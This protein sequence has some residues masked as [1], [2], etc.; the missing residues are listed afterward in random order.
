MDRL[1]EAEKKLQKHFHFDSFRLEQANVI[2][3]LLDEDKQNRNTL[4]IMP[5]GGGK[6]VCFQIPAVMSNGLTIV[7]SPLI[8]L[9]AD[10]VENL[11]DVNIKG[12][13]LNSTQTKEEA[14]AVYRDIFNGSL[15][16][17]YVSPEKVIA[18]DLVA[19]FL[20]K[21]VQISLFAIDEAHCISMWGY[22]FRPDYQ[23]VGEVITSHPEIPVIALTATADHST[24]ADIQKQ[25]KIPNENLF[26]ASFN[27]PNL[28][29]HAFDKIG[30]GVEQ[31][32]Q[33]VKSRPN[34]SGII[35]CFSRKET[36]TMAVKLSSIGIKAE[37]YH[38]RIEDSEKE[39]ILKEFKADKIQVVTA[40]IAFGMGI[41]KPNIRYVIHSTMSQ[42]IENYFQETGRAG[43]DGEEADVALLYSRG[44]SFKIKQM[45]MSDKNGGARG[46]SIRKHK[47][48]KVTEM[49]VIGST[50]G[51][52]TQ[53]L[54]GYFNEQSPACGVC[55]NCKGYN[56]EYEDKSAHIIHDVRNL[57][58]TTKKFDGESLEKYRDYLMGVAGAKKDFEERATPLFGKYKRVTT[59]NNMGHYLSQI[60][61][62]Q[63]FRLEEKCFKENRYYKMR[64]TAKG[65]NYKPV[66]NEIIFTKMRSNI[67]GSY[68]AKID[69]T[70]HKGV[71]LKRKSLISAKNLG[72]RRISHAVA[73]KQ[74]KGKERHVIEGDSMDDWGDVED[75]IAFDLTKFRKELVRNSRNKIQLW[76]IYSNEV[77]S[78]IAKAKPTT[79]DELT[80][81]KGIGPVKSAKY[82]KRIFEIIANN[83]NESQNE[84]EM[85]R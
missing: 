22:D 47:I 81:I 40:T 35:Y 42:S 19:Y 69:P 31:V 27:R 29:Y 58:T 62:Q 30:N 53:A 18:S 32:I 70:V 54:L 60:V 28:R 84:N 78:N 75:G 65:T 74:F 52:R 2:K 83:L 44:D 49:S 39:R 59:K 20:K 26:A 77:M 67:V 64:L 33:M 68:F 43:R 55:D 6:S 50:S 76:N 9:M 71:P 46:D 13:F 66:S 3:S 37:A 15:K 12:G 23:K 41:D 45:I 36:E 7:V 51:C 34:E 10:Q 21:E 56:V 17:L 24:Q 72:S 57:E 63:L 38:G 82:G 73:E 85:D 48:N 5:T 14:K 79:M 4:G 25:L 61:E 11:K 80:Q 16:L 1:N 8:S